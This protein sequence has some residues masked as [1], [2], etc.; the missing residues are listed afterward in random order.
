MTARRVSLGICVVLVGLSLAAEAR[1][2]T[3]SPSDLKLEVQALQTLY[4][5]QFTPQQMQRLVR[6]AADTAPPPRRRQPGRVSEEYSQAL[7]DLRGALLDATDEDRIDQLEDRLEE[8]AESEKPDLDED[9]A[10]T[11]AARRRAAE[12]LGQLKPAQLAHY[13]G[14]LDEDVADPL[15]RLQAGLGQA[16][17]LQGDAWDSRRDEIA[18]EV[19]EY[20]ARTARR[21]VRGI[22]DTLRRILA[23]AE[24]SGATPLTAAMELARKRLVASVAAA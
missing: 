17:K 20:D 23:N 14:Y 6:I 18:E 15:E 8:L 10:L 13:L 2:D 1:P 24:A 3:P 22:G 5:F 12:V 7:S 21:R 19:G 4:R 9:I 11:A 16:R